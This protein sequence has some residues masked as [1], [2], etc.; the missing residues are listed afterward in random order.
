MNLTTAAITL[1]L[2]SSPPVKPEVIG[3]RGDEITHP[4]V[5]SSGTQLVYEVPLRNGRVIRQV[6]LLT[7]EVDTLKPEDR[8]IRDLSWSHHRFRPLIN[9]LTDSGRWAL[10]IGGK[11]P[12]SPSAASDMHGTVSPDKK[13]IAFSSGRTGSGDIYLALTKKNQ[14]SPRRITR[15]PEP[16][17]FP[18]WSPNGEQLLFL[19]AAPQGRSLVLLS[20]VNG[21]PVQEKVLAD[22]REGVLS[23]RWRPDGKAVAFFGRDWGSGT[24]IFVADTVMGGSKKVIGNVLPNRMGPAWVQDKKGDYLLLAIITNDQLVS[25]NEHGDVTSINT[26]LL[27]HG[28][29]TAAT[30]RK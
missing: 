20:G 29:V 23:A 17:L 18:Q 7:G 22:S 30:F 13:W 28:E 27:G 15:S 9:A 4:K 6:R 1:M 8:P 14:Q 10:W 16:E 11:E 2:I 26:G 19:R 25:V 3:K 5:N 21:G 12:S 24:S